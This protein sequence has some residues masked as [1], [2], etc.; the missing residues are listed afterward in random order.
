[1]KPHPVILGRSLR[2]VSVEGIPCTATQHFS[3]GKNHSPFSDLLETPLNFTF[4][5]FTRTLF[6]HRISVSRVWRYGL[7]W[8]LVLLCIPWGCSQLLATSQMWNSWARCLNQCHLPKLVLSCAHWHD[9]ALDFFNAKLF[10]CP[11]L[12]KILF[13]MFVVLVI[14]FFWPLF[15]IHEAVHYHVGFLICYPQA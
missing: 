4:Q 2:G 12:F 6:F 14:V 7:C 11:D 8:S 9:I 3:R 5:S 15:C 1:M 10:P 13:L